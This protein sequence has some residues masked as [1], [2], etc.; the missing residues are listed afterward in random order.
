MDATTASLC[1]TVAEALK[2][3]YVAA[4]DARLD[5]EDAFWI[6]YDEAVVQL[7]SARNLAE[8]TTRSASR[9]LLQEIMILV[10]E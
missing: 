3:L 5:T 7:A 8:S 9:D 2:P 1:R 6:V 4:R 10:M